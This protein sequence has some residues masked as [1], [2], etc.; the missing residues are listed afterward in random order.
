[1]CKALRALANVVGQRIRR[2]E[3]PRFLRGE[4]RYPRPGRVAGRL[5][6]VLTQLQLA[7]YDR[8]E[9]SLRI[10]P[11]AQR[12]NLELSTA[13]TAYTGRL[14]QARAYLGSEATQRAAVAA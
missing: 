2:R 14:E 9:R 8:E 10:D 3:D 5:I 11:A 7:T 4:G 1:M 12:T 6:R 13:F